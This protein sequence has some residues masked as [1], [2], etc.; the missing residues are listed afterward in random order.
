MA[1]AILWVVYKHSID[2]L[3][4]FRGKLTALSAAIDC[5]AGISPPRSPLASDMQ[6]QEPPC[7]RTTVPPMPTILGHEWLDFQEAL[8][9]ITSRRIV[10]KVGSSQSYF[11]EALTHGQ[12][13]RKIA[14]FEIF[15]LSAVLLVQSTICHPLGMLSA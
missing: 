7:A 9:F 12:G 8:E 2:I 5:Q 14:M 3:W 13:M 15:L 11:G 1:V 10:H 6:S 4:V